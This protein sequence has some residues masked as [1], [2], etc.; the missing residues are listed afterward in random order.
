MN[1][2]DTNVL[3]YSVD[4]NEPAKQLKAQQLLSQLH[5]SAE[6]TLLLWQVL[7]EAA[8]Q[9]RR[10]REQGKL[11]PAD[12]SLHIQAFR[13]L[14][15]L[16][17]PSPEA[18]DFALDLAARFSL[19]HWDSMILGACQAAGVKRLFTEDIGAPRTIDGIELVNPFA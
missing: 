15:P 5:S 4:R 16:A 10:W 13:H 1:A 14:F 11:S 12:F 8:Q 6:P 18:F 17:L 19:S 2:I 9:L 3:L 7:G